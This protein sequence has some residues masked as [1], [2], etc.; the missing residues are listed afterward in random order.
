MALQNAKSTRIR[1]PFAIFATRDRF[2]TERPLQHLQ[3]MNIVANTSTI[4]RL[5][6][7]PP[8]SAAARGDPAPR[9][10]CA[11]SKI[12]E[13]SYEMPGNKRR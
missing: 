2:I 6:Q 3:S 9:R 1:V 5:M 10:Q 13:T 7:T 8:G 12:H 4:F 11:K